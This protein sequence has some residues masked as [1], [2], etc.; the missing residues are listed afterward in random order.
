MQRPSIREEFSQLVRYLSVG[1]GLI[2]FR[3]KYFPG[4]IVVASQ[5]EMR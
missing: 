4:P 1:M 2:A 3:A 5:K